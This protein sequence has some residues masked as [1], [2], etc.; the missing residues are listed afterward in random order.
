MRRLD[1]SVAGLFEKHKLL[2]SFQ[3]TVKI[4]EGEGRM[5]RDL[6]EFFAK[7]NTALERSP[8]AK[9]FEWL[10]EQA[11]H[12]MTKLQCLSTDSVFASLAEDVARNELKWKAYYEHE[13][14]EE[15][16]A[17][18]GA[19]REMT[20]FEKLLLLRCLRVD[21]V[22]VAVTSYVTGTLG[23]AY[24]QPPVLHYQRLFEQSSATTPILFVLSP[25]ADPVFDVMRLGER[26]GFKPG[27]R[28]KHIALGQGKRRRP[29]IPNAMRYVL[30]LTGM[31]KKAEEL[32]SVA[33]QRGLWVM[34]Q[35]CHLLPKWLKTLEKW[36]EK[37][38][39]PHSDFR[40]WLTTDPTESFPLGI[41]QRCVKVV[42]EPPNG[43]KPNMR[44]SYSKL[45]DAALSQCPHAAF[46]P[47]VYILSFFHAVVQERR[48]YGTIDGPVGRATVMA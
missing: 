31:G 8:A 32:L 25:G 48:K 1:P 18:L 16:E 42:T 34:L 4:E 30:T 41:L 11:W 3:M 27:H 14:A 26:L 47:L 29:C 7:G 46:K 10:P 28:L 12:D 23:K 13:A 43:L 22:T 39:Q 15:E 44:S 37:T 36:L 24:V 17:P 20:P 45:D 21:R 33:S 40:L 19:A 35:N 6:L 2:F 38:T 9:P 5:Q